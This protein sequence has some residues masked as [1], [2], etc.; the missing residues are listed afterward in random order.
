M[1]SEPLKKALAALHEELGRASA[2]DEK[3][4]Q[5]LRELVRDVEG[6]GPSSGSAP[7]TLHQH[8]L[9]ELAVEFEIDHPTLA[10]VLRQLMDLLTKAGL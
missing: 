3:S 2:L 6:L 8:R 4:R 9:E 5:R 1:N 7:G 10:A